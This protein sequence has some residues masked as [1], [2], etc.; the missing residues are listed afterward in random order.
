MFTWNEELSGQ[1]KPNESDAEL[2]A[3]FFAKPR[4][5]LVTL[6]RS[7]ES[8][9]RSDVSSLGCRPRI[10]FLIVYYPISYSAS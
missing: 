7:T 4:S 9:P 8:L 6:F 2:H 5:Y 10:R 3:S 1:M